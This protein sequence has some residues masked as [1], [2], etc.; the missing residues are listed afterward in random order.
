MCR[1]SDPLVEAFAAAGREAGY[2]ATA[3]YNGAQQEGFA[4]PQ[5]TIRRGRRCSAADAYLRPALARKNLTI[6]THA[7][8]TR[9]AFNGT[10]AAGV[11]YFR[12]GRTVTARAEREVIL[13]GGVINSPQLLMLSGIGEPDELRST[14]VLTS[15]SRCR[16]SAKTCKITSRR[17]SLICAKN[18]D[19]FIG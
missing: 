9:L 16:A 6:A 11:E 1:F 14:S 18:R 12:H 4:V 10:R 8:V 17:S 7:L 5:M 3:D 13:C 19:R 2:P 15:R